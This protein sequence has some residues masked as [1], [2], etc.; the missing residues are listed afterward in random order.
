M[1]APKARVVAWGA[2]QGWTGVHHFAQTFKEAVQLLTG[3]S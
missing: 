1:L 3:N 2:A